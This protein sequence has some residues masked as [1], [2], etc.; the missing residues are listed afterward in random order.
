[1]AKK[2]QITVIKNM[3]NST[4]SNLYSL[5]INVNVCVCVHMCKIIF[6]NKYTVVL[7]L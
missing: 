4:F 6:V 7:T 5:T 3:F 2:R 1:M